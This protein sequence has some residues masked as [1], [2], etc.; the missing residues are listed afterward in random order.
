[1]CCK[2]LRTLQTLALATLVGLFGVSL[3]ACEQEPDNGVLIEEDNGAD[4]DVDAPDDNDDNGIDI[5]T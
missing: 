4:I 1:M 3:A 2:L 5:D